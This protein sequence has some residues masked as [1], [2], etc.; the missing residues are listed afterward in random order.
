MIM[1]RTVVMAAAVLAACG[2]FANEDSAESILIVDGVMK[3]RFLPVDGTSQL[4]IEFMSTGENREKLS[5]VTMPKFWIADRMVTEGEYAA[6][7]GCDVREGRKADDILAEV[8][9]EEVLSLWDYGKYPDGSHCFGTNAVLITDS[10]HDCKKISG[11][12]FQ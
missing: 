5:P 4:P 8:E 3:M 11:G 9:W 2:P 10:E 7:M 12:Q 1:S 6:I